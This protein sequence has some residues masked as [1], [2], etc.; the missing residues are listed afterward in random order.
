MLVKVGDEWQ[1]WWRP[2]LGETKGN[3]KWWDRAGERGEGRGLLGGQRGRVCM[4][5]WEGRGGEG[6][7]VGTGLK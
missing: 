3:H 4:G 1:P 2:H 6:R 5:V 7:R